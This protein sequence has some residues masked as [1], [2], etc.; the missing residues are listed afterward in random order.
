MDNLAVFSH[1]FG[2]PTEIYI[3]RHIAF[4]SPGKTVAFALN[5]VNAWDLDISKLIISEIL[6]KYSILLQDHKKL[7]IRFLLENQVN[8][9]LG[10]FIDFSL[11]YLDLAKKLDIKFFAH[12]HGSDVSQNLLN[13]YFKKQYLRYNYDSSGIIIGTRYNKEKL[14]NIGIK[15]ERIHIVPYGVPVFDL[16]VK[17]KENDFIKCIAVGRMVSKKAPLIL[18][19]A[20]RYA[21]NIFPDL[22][23]DYVGDGDLYYDVCNF[24][25]EFN[26]YD[27]VFLHG[28]L[29]NPEVRRLMLDSDIFVQHSVTCTE[30]GNQENLPIAILEA[31][32]CALP[33]VST[34][35]AGIP[36]AV[37]DGI[38][39]FL[40]NEKDAF[41]MGQK[42]VELASDKSLRMKMGTEG[43]KRIE[44]HF[45]MEN[46]VNLLRKLIFE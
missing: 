29:P 11:D 40:V 23:L 39:G 10:E 15:E 45:S 19:E 18:L 28:N 46:E 25:D 36:E 3:Q 31:M 38:T 35:H 13:E 26:L 37:T 5:S 41:I 7:L 6:K 16:P 33:V 1:H 14:I 8:V 9:I 17:K 21:L 34:I 42:I 2:A 32:A 12:G 20:F 27:K 22:R 44:N 30:T 43:R 4:L 24:L